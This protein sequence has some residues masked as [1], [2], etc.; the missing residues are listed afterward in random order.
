[1][2]SPPSA[3][4]SPSGSIGQRVGRRPSAA[5]WWRALRP[6]T[7][8]GCSRPSTAAARP[9]GEVG[10]PS[11]RRRE[12]GAGDGR[13]PWAVEVGA[14]GHPAQRRAGE[15]LEATPSTTPGCRAG[16][17]PGVRRRATP[18][19]SGFAGLMA[20]CIHRM[21][22]SSSSTTFTK[23]K[24]P[25]LTPPLVTSASQRRRAAASAAAIAPR[26]RRRGRG[27]RPRA[28]LA[29]QRQ[30]RRPVGV[31]DLAGRE[32][33]GVVDQLVAGGDHARPAAAGTDREPAR[34][35]P[36][37]ARRGGR[38]AAP[39]RAASTSSPGCDVARPPAAR[40]CARRRLG[41]SIR[42]T[43]ASPVAPSGALDHHHGVGARGHRRA[44]HDAHRLARA[45]RRGRRPRPAATVPTTASATGWSGG[46]AGDVGGPHGEAVHRRVGE[47]RH[48]PRA[49]RRRRRARSRAASASGTDGAAPAARRRRERR[50]ARASSS[51]ITAACA[52]QTQ[53][54]ARRHDVD[55]ERAELGAEVVALER[56]LDG[57][58][59]VVELLADVVAALVEHVRRRRPGRASS[60][61]MASVSWISPPTPGCTCSSCRRSRA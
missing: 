12:A 49:R 54:R 57:G 37:P 4:P 16:R 14:A 27:R 51:G 15:Q 55:E 45:D 46:G 19:A 40:C 2:T 47:R 22:P 9:R 38:A 11:G 24:S 1:M 34:R 31:A 48:R 25:M 3:T 60:R 33:R 42:R 21:S 44:G 23:S 26:R 50:G 17:T 59:Q 58:P 8:T 61:A 18:K 13:D 32:R 39:C 35:R 28:R 43:V 56:Q 6:A 41:S 29:D 30:Q 20:T 52:D 10:L 7:G 5:S 53:A 36:R